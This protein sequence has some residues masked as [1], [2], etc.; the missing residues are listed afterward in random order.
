MC[1]DL[2]QAGVHLLATEWSDSLMQ[3]DEQVRSHVEAL[4]R[5]NVLKE[6]EIDSFEVKLFV[7]MK[8]LQ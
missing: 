7:M 6:G 3:L 2:S 8:L 1:F 5:N 4:V